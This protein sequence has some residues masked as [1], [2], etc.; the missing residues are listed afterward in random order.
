MRWIVLGVAVLVGC[1]TGAPQ[2][3]VSRDQFQAHLGA[4]EWAKAYVLAATLV[5][6]APSYDDARTLVQLW[7]RVGRPSRPSSRLET[8]EIPPD[9][10]AYVDALT[11]AVLEQYP[12]AIAA[13]RS[14]QSSLAY[15]PENQLNLAE[16]RY[17]EG[18]IAALA[19]LHA[20]AA[21]ALDDASGL[22]PERVDIRLAHAAARL[23]TD[24]PAASIETLRGVLTLRPSAREVD[25]ARELLN[26]AVERSQP[27]LDP[28]TR[29]EVAS[30]LSEIEKDQATPDTAL[31]LRTQVTSASHP[32]LK[33]AAGLVM[34][35]LGRLAEGSFYLVE[36]AEQ[37][38]LDPEPS[39]SLGTTLYAAGQLSR[40]LPH[41]RDAVA[42]DPFDRG[43]LLTLA[44]ASA[45]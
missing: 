18:V 13:V 30:A 19:G 26:R 16:L 31:R 33:T 20:D 34:M 21:V 15:T 43:T 36:A 10:S 12:D 25:R 1:A 44:E 5:C 42:R 38:P 22:N 9:V 35:K 8:C 3:N 40:A 14:A 41:L 24:G 28:T 4:G 23:E 29:V 7:D 11:L 39:R 45:A 27:P 2:Q 17:R 37:S 32:K 6:S